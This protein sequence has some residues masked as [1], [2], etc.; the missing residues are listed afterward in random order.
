MVTSPGGGTGNNNQIA[1]TQSASAIKKA[2]DEALQ[3]FQ[4]QLTAFE[5]EQAMEVV[6]ATN[7]SQAKVTAAQAVYDKA[8]ALIGQ[9]GAVSAAGYAKEVDAARKA[10]IEALQARE[11][12]LAK[13]KA[14][15]A[16]QL[17]GIASEQAGALAVQKA[18][19][20][21]E[22]AAHQ[23]TKAQEL[24]AEQ[25]LVAQ[26]LA[27][28]Q[29]KFAQL[30]S[31]YAGDAQ[32]VTEYAQQQVEAQQKAQLQMVQLQT[33]ALNE[34]EQN[35][36]QAANSMAEDFSRG[37]SQIEDAFREKGQGMKSIMQAAF[38]DI[39][40]IFN[41]L[42]ESM[43]EKWL[44]NSK[45][46]QNFT[47]GMAN[48]GGIMGGI[49]GLFGGAPAAPGAP[50]VPGATPGIGSQIV[51]PG[52]L[53]LP[54]QQ[55]FQAAGATLGQSFQ[56]AFQTSQGVL[57]S[58]FS[59]AMRSAG[60]AAPAAASGGGSAPAAAGSN[61]QLQHAQVGLA[62]AQLGV[63]MASLTHLG[64]MS[65]GQEAMQAI[66]MAIEMI[67]LMI[68]LEPSIFGN[69]AEAGAFVGPGFG[70]PVNDGR[71]GMVGIVH[72]AN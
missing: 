36:K 16:E 72:P 53:N 22:L 43:A 57:N 55:G 12:L 5:Q 70:S 41:H 13:T 63:Q 62:A 10:G 32:K 6:T 20:Q 17:T 9:T 21:E 8:V 45:L 4:T 64:K 3:S 61:T 27:L 1:T 66:L 23:I 52:S 28:E 48:G 59:N 38:G 68:A 11:E 67:D 29:N 26:T 69:K 46:F 44:E 60:S 58:L 56:Q 65:A 34:Q 2:Q 33:Q 7:T 14:L 24:Q 40:S 35:T 30:S 42:I 50:G 54:I 25:N 19:L 49:K 71:G 37:L 39:E 47:G 15:D 31:L 51:P 18:Q